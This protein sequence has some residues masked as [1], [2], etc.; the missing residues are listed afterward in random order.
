MMRVCFVVNTLGLTGGI[1]VVFEHSNKLQERGHDVSIVHLLKLK[2]GLYGSLIGRLKQ[3]KY[4]ILCIL[5]WDEIK[6]FKL[7]KNIRVLHLYSLDKL[8]AVDAII[9]TAN[10]TADWVAKLDRQKGEKFYFV[11]DYENWTREEALVDATYKLPLKKIVVSSWLKTILKDKFNQSVCGVVINGIDFDRFYCRDKK[12]NKNKKILMQY[13]VLPKKGIKIGLEVLKQIKEK[14]KE[15]EI[16]LF[17]V[18][19]PQEK[20]PEGTKYYYKIRQDELI[21]L[22]HSAD[23]FI[24][25]GLQEGF[26]LPPMEAMAAKCAVVVTRVG[27]VPDYTIEN[28][29]AIVIPP[30]EI[31]PLLS[32]LEELI[33]NNDKLRMIAEAGNEHVRYFTWEKASQELESLLLK[34]IIN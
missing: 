4:L 32:A 30:G 18:Y 21:K 20:L 28:K 9:A 23:I 15:V 33:T 26:N 13:H 2:D 19:P 11:Q 6:W 14:F 12:Y 24:S 10:E 17:G 27:A 5:G 3:I 31:R 25:T 1:R 22:Y 7:Q 34:N 16:I 29:T 8:K